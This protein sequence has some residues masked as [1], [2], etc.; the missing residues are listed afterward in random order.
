[1]KPVRDKERAYRF[2]QVAILSGAGEHDETA[3]H[4]ASGLGSGNPI[5]IH[6][7]ASAAVREGRLVE[8]EAL[9]LEAIRVTERLFDASHPHL[10]TI[11]FGLV[12][13]YAKQGRQ[14]EALRVSRGVAGRTDRTRAVVANCRTL[15]R[16]AE[17]CRLAGRADD[18]IALFRR[19]LAHRRRVHGARHP[20]V[21]ECLAAFAEFQQRAGNCQQARALLRKAVAMLDC[22]GE[23]ASRTVSHAVREA[24]DLIAHAA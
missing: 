15:A 20:K 14:D 9:Y 21:A 5:L 13:L 22:G 23:A 7:E 4:W 8:A 2:G 10:A 6:A 24:R 12:Q 1:M 11:A 17:L 18:G 3:F 19:A 16:L